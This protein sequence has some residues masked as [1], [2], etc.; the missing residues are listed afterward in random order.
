MKNMT[1]R[2][3]GVCENKMYLRK[4]TYHNIKEFQEYLSYAFHQKSNFG[5][6]RIN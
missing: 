1:Y 3:K 2:K 6:T 4:E 5:I